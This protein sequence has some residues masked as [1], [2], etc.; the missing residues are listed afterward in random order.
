MPN[1]VLQ[2]WKLVNTPCKKLLNILGLEKQFNEN[3]WTKNNSN[4]CR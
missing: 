3:N 1:Q 2:L 4:K